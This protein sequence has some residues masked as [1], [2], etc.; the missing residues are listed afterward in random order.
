MIT[1]I[2]EA[3]TGGIPWLSAKPVPVNVK[4][5]GPRVDEDRL[6]VPAADPLV[7]RL[8]VHESDAE[9]DDDEKVLLV[10]DPEE[11][12]A[13]DQE[14][15]QRS[16]AERG[17]DGEAVRP[18]SMRLRAAVI[19][20]ETALTTTAAASSPPVRCG[21][22]YGRR[23]EATTGG[24]ARIGYPFGPIGGGTDPAT[25]TARDRISVRPDARGRRRTGRTR[26]S[27]ARIVAAS[28]VILGVSVPRV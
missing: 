19:I 20:P 13:V 5:H 22:G 24:G 14:I 3:T 11:R 2:S 28:P 21:T 23:G 7:D 12:P 15:A 8:A 4:K 17:D 6:A 26:G 25:R 18:T 9:D 10:A 1:P 27:G 16:S